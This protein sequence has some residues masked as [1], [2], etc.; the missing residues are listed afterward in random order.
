MDDAV[1]MAINTASDV[2]LLLGAGEVNSIKQ[3]FIDMEKME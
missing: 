2:I 3:E 1:R